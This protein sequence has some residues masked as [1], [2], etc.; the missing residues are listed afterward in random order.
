MF[1]N[2][3][4]HLILIT[5]MLPTFHL[6]S[7]NLH[8]NPATYLDVLPI[9]QP[10]HLPITYLPTYLHIHPPI[11]Y[12]CMKYLFIYLPTHPPPNHYLPIYLSTHL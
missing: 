9:Y 4:G 7:Y 11:T 6:Q 1:C 10:I 8:T 12:L 3:M 2:Q 5:Y